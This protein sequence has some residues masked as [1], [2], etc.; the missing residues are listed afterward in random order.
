VIR[1][2]PL[3]I[4][5]SA[6]IAVLIALVAWTELNHAASLATGS[7]MDAYWNAAMR[8]RDGDPL[9]RPGIATDSDLYRYAP[10]FAALW[11]P[12]TY[13][14]K[15]AVLLGW[16]VL[17]LGAAVLSVAP[18]LREGPAGWAA[19]AFLL[20][21]QLE[22]AAFGNVQPILVLALLWGAPRRSGPLW[23]A[24]G[25]S[26]KIVPLLL[27]VVYAGRGEWRRAGLSVGLTALLVA[28]MLLFD[29]GGYS[30]DIG[31]GQL[32]LLTISPWLFV[33]V[34]LAAAV[35]AYLLAPTRYAWAFGSLAMMLAL[36]R[37][38][39]YEIS[40][41]VVGLARSRAQR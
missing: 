40:F 36:P 30:T 41:A 29:L 24:L 12:L 9:Y 15:D 6:V 7:D 3:V 18:L 16:M 32:S 31:A 1:G 39:I 17:C 11:I 20:P 37:F 8:L 28:P 13:L 2:S 34:L 21:F 10:W 5:G 27:A 14:P 38:L 25:A 19:L 4:A 35:V 33:T 26:L 22:G 23:I